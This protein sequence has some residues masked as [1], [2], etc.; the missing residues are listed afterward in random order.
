[1]T[2][3]FENNTTIYPNDA[4][5]R[6]IMANS[7]EVGVRAQLIHNRY[8]EYLN[9]RPDPDFGDRA[10]SKFDLERADLMLSLSD[11]DAEKLYNF[12]HCR[13]VVSTVIFL[14][15][16]VLIIIIIRLVIGY[17]GTGYD[18]LLPEI[19]AFMAATAVSMAIG[20]FVAKKKYGD[21]LPARF[22]ENHFN[23]KFYDKYIVMKS[24]FD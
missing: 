24:D 11:K 21:K 3:F 22:S 16:F 18:E 6:I 19:P 14:I 1:M 8:S 13:N 7:G 17:E 15:L 2:L 12:K 10:K 20:N 9:R 4:E 5:N 23:Y